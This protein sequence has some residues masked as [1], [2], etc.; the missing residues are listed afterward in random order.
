M[1]P[2]PE[3]RWPDIVYIQYV[4][5][6]LSWNGLNLYVCSTVL[7]CVVVVVGRSSLIVGLSSPYTTETCGDDDKNYPAFLDLASALKASPVPAILYR[8]RN[9]SFRLLAISMYLY[10]AQGIKNVL[11]QMFHLHRGTSSFEA[12]QAYRSDEGRFSAVQ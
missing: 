3:G 4:P 11:R 7:S 9:F 6:A 12:H 2:F 8:V 1:G 5:Y 10:I